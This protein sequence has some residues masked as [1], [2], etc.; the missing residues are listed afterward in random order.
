MD[1]PAIRPATPFPNSYWV[2]DHLLAGEHPALLDPARNRQRAAGLI[3]A[4]I[5]L[6]VDL[7]EPD[8]TADLEAYPGLIAGL[9]ADYA[10]RC[11]F[12]RLPIPDMD[13]PAPAALRALLEQIDEARLDGR[14]A[15][16][17]CWGG[18]GRTGT[19]VGCYL[20]RHGMD[21]AAAIAELARLRAGTPDAR[22]IAP[23]RE[24]QRQMIL[25]WPVSAPR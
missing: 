4:G 16:V 21:G 20:V 17:H 8:E 19:L 10:R 25:G 18:I 15:Y 2:D 24:S 6:F 9:D 22:Y 11:V 23:A 5:T 3:A 1:L 12:Q 7:T 14:R 13:I